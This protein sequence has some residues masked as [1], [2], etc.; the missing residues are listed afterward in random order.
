MTISASHLSSVEGF[1][2]EISEIEV[3]KLGLCAVTLFRQASTRPL[4]HTRC[5]C[6]QL[7]SSY[8]IYFRFV[9]DQPLDLLF[10]LMFGCCVGHGKYVPLHIFF[11]C[12]RLVYS[13]P[14]YGSVRRQPRGLS[15]SVFG[16]IM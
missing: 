16:I 8:P 4:V 2:P 12:D 13:N 15:I 9:A 6:V 5:V 3:F 10:G 14:K 7:L 11:D 1:Q